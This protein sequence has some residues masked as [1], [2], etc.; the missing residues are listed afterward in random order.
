MDEKRLEDN[1]KTAVFNP[2]KDQPAREKTPEENPD[3]AEKYPF[4]PEES[5]GFNED[6]EDEDNDDEYDEEDDDDESEDSDK[7]NIVLI[8]VTALAT[9]IFVVTCI[10]GIS[11][12]MNSRK[13][14]AEIVENEKIIEE[15]P[16]KIEEVPE[17]PVEEE[18]NTVY[19]IAFMPDSVEKEG[20]TYTVRVT[21][22]NKSMTTEGEKRVVLNS[23]TE[24]VEDGE[25]LSLVSFISVI[26]SIGDEEIIFKGKIN[27]KTREVINISYNSSI[28][29]VLQEPDLQPE[30][31]RE[32]TKENQTEE[33]EVPEVSPEEPE[34]EGETLE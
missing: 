3:S 1:E 19:S 8:V 17:K 33:E 6:F 22:Y 32:V 2:I 25:E 9:I 10:W 16:E 21:L 28:L 7:L 5:I 13:E 31:E 20:D 24:I 15:I 34:N 23:S 11:T 30:I 12:F 29:E 27:E 14:K 18:K 26:E 4:Q